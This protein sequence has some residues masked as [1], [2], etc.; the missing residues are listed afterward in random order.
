MSI[1]KKTSYFDGQTKTLEEF[2]NYSS[3]IDIVSKIKKA[4]IL[5]KV[6]YNGKTYNTNIRVSQTAKEDLERFYV[7]KDLN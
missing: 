4:A 3:W 5:L 1:P 6:E 7:I 2:S